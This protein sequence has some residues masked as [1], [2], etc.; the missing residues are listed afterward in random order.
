MSCPQPMT[1]AQLKQIIRDRGFSVVLLPD[2]TT[3]LRGKR[4]EA[5]PALMRVVAYWRDEFVREL[6]GEKS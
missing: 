1:F 5:T 4:A 3:A 2:G 6:K